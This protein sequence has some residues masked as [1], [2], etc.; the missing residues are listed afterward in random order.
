MEEVARRGK[1]TPLHTHPAEEETFYVDGEALMHLDGEQW[2]VTSGCFVSV[3]PGV[4][5]AYL[6]TS[7]TARTLVLITPGSGAMEE[8][9]RAAGEPAAERGL[10]AARPARHRAN[11]AGGPAHRR[12]G[13]SRASAL[14]RSWR[15][16]HPRRTVA[17][18]R[19]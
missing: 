15:L 4:P 12:R 17:F 1:V 5:H 16:I 11:R 7:E 10:P 3:P 2:S 18:V 19:Q 8:F 9:F 6:A 14:R 13:D